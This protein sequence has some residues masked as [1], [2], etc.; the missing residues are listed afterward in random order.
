MKEE[1]KE[2][3]RKA[4]RGKKLSEA[5]KKKIGEGV[6]KNLPKTSFKKGERVSLETEF[7]KGNIPWNKGK[8]TDVKPWLGKKLSDAHKIKMSKA[9]KG[10]PSWNKDKNMPQIAGEKHYNWKGGVTNENC[11]VRSSLEYR[12]WRK[13]NLERDYFM[14]QKCK[15]SGGRLKVHHINNF[16]DFPELRLAIDNG[17]TFCRECHLEFHNKYGRKNN[18]KGQLIKFM[19]TK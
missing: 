5:H 1:T 7:P 2:K 10:K 15:K 14:C 13:A 18:T 12:L 6:K 8:R 4:K 19:D 9:K 11:K 16:A 17:I 3:I